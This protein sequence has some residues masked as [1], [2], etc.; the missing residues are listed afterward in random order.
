MAEIVCRKV[1]KARWNL[2]FAW[3]GKEAIQERRHLDH[4][5]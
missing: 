4:L 5:A 2:V 1:S 3:R